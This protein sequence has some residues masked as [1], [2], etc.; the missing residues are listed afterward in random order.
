MV[1]RNILGGGKDN[2]FIRKEVTTIPPIWPVGL[3]GESL[4]LTRFG[5][6]GSTVLCARNGERDNSKERGSYKLFHHPQSKRDSP[7]VICVAHQDE[8]EK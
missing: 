1:R 6:E 7:T 5:R 2:R 3:G 4:S 8:K